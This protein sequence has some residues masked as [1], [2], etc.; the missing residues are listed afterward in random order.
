MMRLLHS[1]IFFALLC[2]SAVPSALAQPAPSAS[3]AEEETPWGKGV[4]QQE[5]NQARALLSEGNALYT[6]NLYKEALEKYQNAIAHWNHPAICFNVVRSLVALDR[7]DEA[8]PYIDRALAFGAAPLGADLFGEAQNYQRLLQGQVGQVQFKCSHPD[9]EL[10]FDGQPTKCSEVVNAKAGRHS[11]AASKPSYVPVSRSETIVPG[12][13][14]I[15]FTLVTIVASTVTKTRW[16]KWKPWA[17]VGAGASMVAIGGGIE[18]SAGSVRDQ[19]RSVLTAECGGLACT[20]ESQGLKA[21]HDSWRFRDSVGVATMAIGAGTL[22]A[23]CVLLVMNRSYVVEAPSRVSYG[24][25]P[26]HGTVWASGTF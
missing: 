6:Q 12:T 1:T 15:D 10:T 11:I 21:L 24:L 14:V 3:A 25:D 8:V 22:I 16:A 9:L 2:S 17:V 13:N 4:A 23:G 20:R 18:L 5:K 19:Y 7:P 26:A